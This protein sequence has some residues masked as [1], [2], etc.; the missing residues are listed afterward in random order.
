MVDDIRKQGVITTAI[1]FYRSY[2]Y[3][4]QKLISGTVSQVL[5]SMDPVS[6]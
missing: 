2:K 6:P 3:N 4:R 1:L 5:L